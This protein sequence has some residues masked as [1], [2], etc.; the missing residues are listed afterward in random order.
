MFAPTYWS[1]FYWTGFYWPPVVSGGGSGQA[2]GTEDLT[3][4]LAFYMR[5]LF[6]GDQSNDLRVYAD[7]VRGVTG[8]EDTNSAMFV[9]L[10]F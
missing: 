6:P 3:T 10:N 9:D 7:D 2:Y 4:S 8:N 5:T 1:K